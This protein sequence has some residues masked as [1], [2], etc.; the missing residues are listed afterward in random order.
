VSASQGDVIGASPWGMRS[1]AFASCA[2]VV[3]LG[4]HVAAGGGTPDVVTLLAAPVLVQVAHRTA[5]R[6]TRGRVA[7]VL[8]LLITQT[9]LHLLFETSLAGSFRAPVSFGSAGPIGAGH[10]D[11]LGTCVGHATA[12]AVTGAHHAGSL[13]AAVVM[14][15]AHLACAVL[16]G[17]L[18]RRGD[19]AVEALKGLSR[20]A[21]GHL[22]PG[23][24]RR[25]LAAAVRALAGL[26][27]ALPAALRTDGPAR[28]D[29]YAP[30]WRPCRRVLVC[31][32]RSWRGPPPM[33]S[34][35]PA[36]RAAC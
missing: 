4:A 6:R 27:A 33:G 16:L 36:A 23:A 7:T 25:V 3:S 11:C 29:G 10:A 12:V 24:V 31:G 21:A 35:L 32:C 13:P 17:S 28:P 20:G 9:L 15:V 18:L 30:P 8:A 14:A 1:A 5:F 19:V 2:V 22:L 26:T 34:H